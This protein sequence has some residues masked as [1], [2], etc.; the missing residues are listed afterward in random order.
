M[1]ISEAAYT[2][3]WNCLVD[4]YNRPRHIVS[5]LL[6]TFMGLPKTNKADIAI[7]RKVTDGATEIV[8]GLDAAGQSNRDCWIIH[9]VLA[10]TDAETRRKWIEGSRELDDPKVE[11]LFRFLDR[12][13]EEFELSQREAEPDKGIATEQP[14]VKRSSQ[15]LVAMEV[16]CAKCNSKEHT[17]YTCPQFSDLTV[18]QRRTF[19]KERTLCFNCL[20][21][22]HIS[23]KCESKYTCKNCQGR[24]HTLLHS[25]N[26]NGQTTGG[27]TQ[28]GMQEQHNLGTHQDTMVTISHISRAQ[29]E[30]WVECIHG[31]STTTRTKTQDLRKGALPTAQVWVQNAQ[32]SNTLCRV[33]LDSGSE[34]SYISERCIQALGI[35]RTPS[36][37]LVSGISSINADATRGC[38][39]LHIKSRISDDTMEVKAHVLSKI[40]STL[41]RHDIEAHAL[42]I[43]DG[44]QLADSSYR[45]LAPIDILLGSD[46]VW[47]VFTGKKMFDREGNIIAISS[48]FGW[49]I[50]AIKTGGSSTAATLHTT[51]DIDSSLKRFWELEEVNNKGYKE[52][53]DEGVEQHFLDTHTRDTNGKYIVQLPFK[54][55]HQQ[56]ADTLQG[57]LSRFKAVERR[58]QRDRNLQTQY[59]QFMRD[60][61]DLGHMRELAPE[62]ID[63]GQTYYLP[64]HPVITQK[65]RHQ[66]TSAILVARIFD[67]LGLIA[68]VVV[69]FKI[70]FQDLWLLD[71]DWDTQLP[72]KLA[73]WWHKC[74]TDLNTLQRLK[75]PRFIDNKEES[76]E[77]HGFSD[78]SIKAY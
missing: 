10:K 50:T 42:K 40:T 47:A 25:L 67:P 27:R 32:G 34:L 69:Q 58:L 11:D 7:L 72:P 38:S 41:A 26:S 20:K 68:P 70:L 53:D 45:S 48:I 8:R 61:E 13:C 74:C 57:S 71:L 4:R 56:F 29:D 28:P 15:A 66:A 33:L 22:G 35:A 65:L 62:E 76:I 54:T 18:E 75:I 6:D 24:H 3:A 44:F 23:R 1:P 78:A 5:A 30:K 55:E 21:A 2:A 16:S 39:K 14:K 49:V 52:P 19:V 46:H 43:F 64:H 73:D 12:R 77:L 31:T 36:R 17:L 59:L 37:I 9:L 51:I 63:I 60:Y